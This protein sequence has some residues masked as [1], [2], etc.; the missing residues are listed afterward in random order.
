[1]TDDTILWEEPVEILVIN[2]AQVRELLP[3]RACIDVM[4]DALQALSRGEAQ[5]PLRSLMGLPDRR[6]LLALMP[7]FMGDAMGVKVIS[8]MP[9]NH[10]TE[11]DSHMG[12]VM[13]FEATYGRPLA[14]IDASE[15]TAIRTAA[16]S[17]VATRL[18]AR[19]D[20]GDLAILGTGVQADSHLEAMLEVRPIRRVRVWSRHADHRA[21]FAARTQER[22]GVAV[23]PAE[24]AESAVRGADLI[25]TATSSSEPVLKGAW[26]NAGAHLNVVG[27][28]VRTAREVDSDA[29]QRAE[30]FVDRRESTLNEAGDVLIPK[31]EGLIGDDHIRAELGDV[32]LGT[33]PG[34]TSPEAITLFKSLGLAV[35]DLASAQWIYQ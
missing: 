6:G 16:V 10:G 31:Q 28:S 23:E 18:L 13:L 7:S 20:A 19:E 35:E 17:G 4:G 1:M 21:Q 11:Y 9:G 2:A 26:L 12:A 15:I 27:A 24:D 14:L 3:M 29:M 32:L 5:N 33:H 34:R 30:L 8:V 22:Y 25:C